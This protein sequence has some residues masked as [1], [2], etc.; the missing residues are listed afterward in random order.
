MRATE[1]DIFNSFSTGTIGCTKTKRKFEFLHYFVVVSDL[2]SAVLPIDRLRALRSEH[3]Y[4]MLI[5]VMKQ[6]TTEQG[7]QMI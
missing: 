4:L 7:I 5:L 3:C 2:S 1:V 6:M